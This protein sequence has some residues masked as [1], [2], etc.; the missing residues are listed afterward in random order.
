MIY[1]LQIYFSIGVFFH[2][3]FV[4]LDYLSKR[5]LKRHYFD[6]SIDEKIGA[7]LSMLLFW[8]WI[9]IHTLSYYEEK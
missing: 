2:I 5:P 9:L 4:L 8:P 6:L 1:F 3:V 7:S